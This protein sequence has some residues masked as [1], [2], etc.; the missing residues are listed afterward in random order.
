MIHLGGPCQDRAS[1]WAAQAGG[2]GVPLAHQAQVPHQMPRVA[3]AHRFG[4]AV[5]DRQSKA[6]ALQKCAKIA[7]FRHWQNARRQAPRDLGLGHSKT[8]AQFLQRL[9]AEQEAEE[10]TVGHKRVARLH[11]LA[12][13]IIRPMQP[14]RMHHKV[15]AVRSQRKGL[16][17]GHNRAE[18]APYLCK[19]CDDRRCRKGFV[20]LHQSFLHL[21][22]NLFVQEELGRAVSIAQQG[23]AVGQG[24]RHLH[25]AEDE[26]R[27]MGMQACL[28]L[29]YPPQCIVCDALVTSDFGLC[30]AC[31]RET[32]FITGL[33]CDKCGVPL[34]GEDP[35]HSVHCDDCLRIARP[36]SH[37]R[38]AMLYRDRARDMVLQLKHADRID[39]ARP[40]GAWLARAAQPLLRPDQLMAP[41]PLHWMRLFRRKYNQSA[42]LAQEVAKISGIEHCPDLLQRCR[43]TG[44]QEGRDH[45]GRFRNLADAIRVHPKRK[46]Q[47][48]GRHIV[49]VDDVMTSGATLAAAAEAC[50][51]EGASEISVIT[52]TRVAK[53]A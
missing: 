14:K 46:S 37:G 18:T 5:C 19:R 23:G 31:W 7:D 29:I 27:N 41:V 22:R 40:T 3:V 49:L 43:N 24:W 4:K 50:L 13:R 1:G 9:A 28:H 38:A 35:G 11:K 34:P 16:I 21:G 45:D 42:L 33:V 8:G 26:G 48:I 32:P 30:G 2:K 53:D 51:A 15:M 44:S 36:W 17:V 10:Q 6:C 25:G 47:V 52:L 39:L 12:Y 20:N